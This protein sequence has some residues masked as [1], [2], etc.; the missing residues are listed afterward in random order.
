MLKHTDQPERRGIQRLKLGKGSNHSRWR[1][2]L[3]INKYGHYLPSCSSC[4]MSIEK[5][6]E[7]STLHVSPI[8]QCSACSNWSYSSSLVQSTELTIEVLRSVSDRCYKKLIDGDLTS[9]DASK[10]LSSYGINT[11]YQE[12]LILSASNVRLYNHLS[13]EFS[14]D[15]TLLSII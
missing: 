11:R 9:G 8:P 7:S 14:N 15:P 12:D 4:K 5:R 13:S 2:E 3:D 6:F 1:Y 10:F